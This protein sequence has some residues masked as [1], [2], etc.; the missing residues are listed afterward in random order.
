MSDI[1]IRAE[2]LGKLYRLGQTVGYGTL[3]DSITNVMATPFRWLFSKNHTRPETK[4][5]AS[6][7]VLKDVSFEV[8]QGE[9]LAIIGGNGAGKSTLL[10]IL[11]RITT[12]TT[13]YAEIHGRVGSLLEIGTGFHP[14]LSGRENIY[15][16]GS[17]LGMKRNEIKRVFDQ[18]VDFA[19]VEKFI[20]TPVKRYSSGMYVRLGFAIAAHLEPEIMIV[21]EVL[22]VGDV[23]FQKKCMGKM[24]DVANSGRTILF[25]SHNM[26]AVRKLCSRA[27]LLNHGL[28]EMDGNIS[29]VVQHYLETDRE[30][31]SRIVWSIGQRPGNRSFKINS[32]T[33]K[34]VDG[35]I[36]T[37]VEIS[38]GGYVEIDF[39]VIEEKSQAIFALILHDAEGNN[40]FESFSNTELD[41]YGKPL[42]CGRYVISCR[43]QGNILGAGN[44]SVT[45]IG[46]SAQWSE[47]FRLEGVLSFTAIDDG[48]LGRDYYGTYLGALRPKLEWNTRMLR[49]IIKNDNRN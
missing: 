1:A 19:G 6:I 4:K 26:A 24:G 14:E 34:N 21:D 25:V 20:D 37:S 8:R 15:F 28:V 9:A 27:I 23:A 45:I 32:I 44:F 5:P 40:L 31:S 43:L 30:T 16:N 22:A 46:T 36:S 7:W 17:V 12:P 49:G 29:E 10:K 41:Y 38:K 3:R 42:S 11:S 2:N 48:V 39:E 47:Y 35:I 18:I 33:L 13:G